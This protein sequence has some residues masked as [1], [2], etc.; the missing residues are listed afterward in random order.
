MLVTSIAVD[1]GGLFGWHTHP[2]PMLVAVGE[3]TLAVYEPD[4]LRC[5]RSTVSAGQAFV[6]DGGDVHLAGNEG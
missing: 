5:P 4:G 3:G 6:E 1:C 2:G